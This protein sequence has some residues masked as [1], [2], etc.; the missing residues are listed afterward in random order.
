MDPTGKKKAPIADFEHHQPI[1]DRRPRL[2]REFELDRPAGLLLDDRRAVAQSPAD[3]QIVDLQTDEVA[4]A[5]FAI[6]CQVEH[7]EVAFARF[8]LKPGPDIP[9][10]LRLEGTFLA[11]KAPLV[12]WRLPLVLLLGV[13]LG[14]GSSSSS[15]HALPCSRFL[16]ARDPTPWQR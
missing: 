16:R 6:Y 1:L 12:P 3:A 11:D 10:F 8:D 4:A 5:Q 9:D 14:H 7:R 2:L 15:D 13:G